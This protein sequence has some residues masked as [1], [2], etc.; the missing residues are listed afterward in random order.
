M[1]MYIKSNWIR[2]WMNNKWIK[3]YSES[4]CLNGEYEEP[5]CV[6]IVDQRF[7]R[8]CLASKTIM[9]RWEEYK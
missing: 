2:R 3:D 5:D 1:D 7:L 6:N 8:D 4:I 9:L